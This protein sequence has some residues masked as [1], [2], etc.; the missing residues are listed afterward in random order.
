MDRAFYD[1]LP[2]LT[3]RWAD[4]ATLNACLNATSALFL[5]L[6]RRAIRRLEIG[7][8]RRL[9]ISAAVTSGLFLVSYLTYHAKAGSVRF[10]GTGLVRPVYFAILIS[11]TLLA[12]A[13]PP[14]A[15]RALYLGLKRRDEKHRR[16]ARW[17]YPIWLYVSVTGVLVY[18]MLY[19]L[20]AP[21]GLR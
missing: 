20:Y 4:L 6:G 18:L 5:L 2:D 10:P 7:R 13:V 3:F 9:M 16:V 1:H 12:A 11:H 19:R 14:L 21:G 8:H 17:A 15:L